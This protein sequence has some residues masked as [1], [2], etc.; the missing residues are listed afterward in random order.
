MQILDFIIR[1]EK[2]FNFNE[3]EMTSKSRTEYQKVLSNIFQVN[4]YFN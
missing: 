2:L 1:F 4:L 3:Y